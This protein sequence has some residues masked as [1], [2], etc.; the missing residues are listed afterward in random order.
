MS[1]TLQQLITRY[2]GQGIYKKPTTQSNYLARTTV[3]SPS[4]SYVAEAG[5][6][7]QISFTFS[8]EERAMKL[9]PK[10]SEVRLFRMLHM[11]QRVPRLIEKFLNKR[12]G[13]SEKDHSKTLDTDMELL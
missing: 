12:A 6:A 9:S 11:L 2:G 7:K 1:S 4:K 3:S 10:Y 13:G 8:D 5:E